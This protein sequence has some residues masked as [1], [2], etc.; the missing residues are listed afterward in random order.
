[1]CGIVGLWRHGREDIDDARFRAVVRTL[2]HRGPDGEGFFHDAEAR[3]RL[4]HRR[5]AILDPTPAGAQPMVSDD[6]DL[7]I[8]YN[9]EIYDFLELRRELEGHGHR[10]RT[11]TDT[12][13]LLAA[14]RQWG[15][16][17]LRRLNGMWAFAIWDR[18]E[19]QLFAARDRFGVKPFLFCA[20]DGMF[21]FASELKAFAAMPDL[22]LRLDAATLT[23]SPMAMETVGPTLLEGIRSLP[24]GNL[25]HVGRDGRVR[26]RQWWST[27][28]NLPDVPRDHATQV[29]AFR[30]L[31]ADACRVRLRSD[32]PLGTS[33]SGGLDSSSVVAMV[34]RVGG[35]QGFTADWQ[36]VFSQGN[37][38]TDQ[39]ES[40]WARLVASHLDAEITWTDVS[41]QDELDG[42]EASVL[43]F[44]G[45]HIL[46]LGLWSHY[47]SLREHGVVISI[48]GHGGDELLGGYAR[49][50]DAMRRRALRGLRPGQWGAY[51]DTALGLR[52]I[53][54]SRAA[55]AGVLR[56]DVRDLLSPAAV[57]EALRGVIHST[58]VGNALHGALRR[59]LPAGPAASGV[60]ALPEALAERTQMLDA[61][62]RR[63]KQESNSLTPLGS[64]LYSAFHHGVL[65]SILRNFDRLS[66]ASGVEI[67]SPLLDWRLVTFTMALPDE[68]RISGG[69]TK[70]ILR[71]ATVDLLPEAVRMRR[72]KKGFASPMIDWLGRGLSARAVEVVH[73]ERFLGR[74]SWDGKAVRDRLSAAH[75][76]RDW[77]AVK[78][79]W[80]LVQ[81]ELLLA[82]LE[83]IAREATI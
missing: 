39:D 43:A 54:P 73:D 15:E 67:R 81:A 50:S 60:R 64:M 17:M 20:T 79:D 68:A 77:E 31:L 6:G 71:D 10:F 40:D 53:E 38:G 22:P 14:Y 23:F 25:L 63:L 47:R 44:E 72:D 37:V 74:E 13:V 57:R 70:R 51:A 66:M 9:G 30:E 55:R 33:L 35:Q 36:R 27:A 65:P 8:V 29:E 3:L 5:L 32:V 1:M 26:E 78:S 52:G 45:V 21:A 75:A 4:G 49:D 59:S 42:L 28:E 62:V 76:R 34:H 19:R 48:D 41:V 83:R 2:A 46:P 24:P 18:R 69:F 58:A 61:R 16:D 56:A 7:I 82:G 11:D 80:P 12:E